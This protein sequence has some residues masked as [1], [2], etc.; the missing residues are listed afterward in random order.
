MDGVGQDPN[1]EWNDIT[2]SQ[3]PFLDRFMAKEGP[4]GSKSLFC[5]V[6]ASE[7]PVGL[8]SMGYMENSEVGNNV[9]GAFCVFNQGE[10]PINNAFRS[11]GFKSEVWQWLVE[12]CRAEDGNTFDM[13]VLYSDGHL[14]P[15][16]IHFFHLIDGAIGDGFKRIRIHPLADGRSVLDR[17][18]LDYFDPLEKRLATLCNKQI[19]TFALVAVEED[20]LQLWTGTELTGAW[21]KMYGE[22]IV[23]V[24]HSLSL[25]SAVLVLFNIF[26]RTK[27]S[28]ISTCLRSSFWT[29]MLTLS[30]L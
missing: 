23:A 8:P 25:P 28:W 11:G 29:T 4:N 17:S 21:S 30:D 16:V 12:N 20:W 26:I 5:E 9:L 7:K 6:H 10:K 22:H 19:G 14:H 15:H 2:T 1:A 3:T 18:A 27:I 13:I 24:I